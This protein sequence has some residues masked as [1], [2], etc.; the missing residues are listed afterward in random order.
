M[1]R[2]RGHRMP[3][4]TALLVA[5]GILGATLVSAAPVH[6]A[7]AAS[8]VALPG[9]AKADAL[10]SD[11]APDGTP[12]Q[13]TA[14]LGE[15]TVPVL[16]IHGW[17]GKSTHSPSRDGA[18]SGNIDLTANGVADVNVGRSAIGQIQ[19]LGGASAYTFDYH[20]FSARWVDDDMIA[21]R[22]A[23]AL[24]CLAEAHAQEVI[25]V[26]HSMGGLATRAALKLV[27]DTGTAPDAVVS[28]VITFG[29]PNTGSWVAGVVANVIEIARVLPGPSQGL[30]SVRALLTVCGLATTRSLPDSGLCAV[31]PPAGSFDSEAGRALRM[32][33]PQ[34][35]ALASWPG[36]VAVH[37]LAGDIGVEVVR[38]NWF[39]LERSAEPVRVGD[40]IVTGDSAVAGTTPAGAVSCE[41]TMDVGAATA[42]NILQAFR[43]LSANEARDNVYTNLGGSACFHGNLM[44]SIELTNAM[45]GIVADR[46][47]AVAEGSFFVGATEFVRLDPWSTSE[48]Q[49]PL[50]GTIGMG[51]CY[52]A[53]SYRADFLL[54][55][56]GMMCFLSDDRSEALCGGS[57]GSLTR[58]R[59]VE[60]DLRPRDPGGVG[61][62]EI[63]PIE[64][65]TAS[66][67]LCRPRWTGTGFTGPDGFGAWATTCFPPGDRGGSIGGVTWSVFGD[68]GEEFGGYFVGPGST[69]HLRSPLTTQQ[70]LDEHMDPE[71]SDY[72]GP[73]DLADIVAVYY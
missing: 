33:S 25:V 8:C 30:V 47:D 40:F 18:F 37:A 1:I 59:T 26:A 58:S 32:G 10:S 51:G 20:E 35:Q 64:F 7:T 69:G 73:Y 54:C 49:Q 24:T 45:L 68:D 13:E 27:A 3:R 71:W 67:L 29:T 21:P 9:V 63:M 17:T 48:A 52:H 36:G 70:E 2:G 66:G 60:L 43:L 55:P 23:A 46:L 44:R 14:M 16:F 31:F 41:Y 62:A 38:A 28:D 34:I 50:D 42:D 53:A 6:A 11:T 15:R 19:H 57:L 22:L 72:E 56:A 39:R 4:L 65:E 5:L 61:V 12:V